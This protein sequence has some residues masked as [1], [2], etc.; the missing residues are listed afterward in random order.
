MANA[1]GISRRRFSV[2][3][4]AR[5]L[6]PL[7]HLATID[8]LLPQRDS[9]D[10][11]QLGASHVLSEIFAICSRLELTLVCRDAIFMSPNRLL[12]VVR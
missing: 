7:T 4:S 8:S 6:F 12:E 3:S 5:E 2:L 10:F 9:F 11:A 1:I